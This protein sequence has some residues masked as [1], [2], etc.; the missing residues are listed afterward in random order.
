[1]GGWTGG[2]VGGLV[3]RRG[4]GCGGE[5]IAVKRF[6]DS[7]EEEL[8]GS[9]VDFERFGIVPVETV[10]AIIRVRYWVAR[11]RRPVL[12]KGVEKKCSEG[13]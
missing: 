2:R 4:R 7:V 5:R 12:V 11:T 1:M 6:H 10:M 13:L 9:V 8:G 3:L